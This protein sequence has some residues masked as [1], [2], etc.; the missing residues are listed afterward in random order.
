ME[1][2]GEPLEHPRG[3]RGRP[4]R[5]VTT[6]ATEHAS[7]S[8]GGFHSRSCWHYCWSL[9]AGTETQCYGQSVIC[10][11]RSVKS[12]SSKVVGRCSWSYSFTHNDSYGGLFALSGASLT[13]PPIQR[14]AV[15]TRVDLT[16]RH[17]RPELSFARGPSSPSRFDRYQSH[18]I[19]SHRKGG[20]L[21]ERLVG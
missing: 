8:V 15:V 6:A 14:S 17:G 1:V 2:R 3:R 21:R 12:I 7:F 19:E 11:L 10:C 4:R 18:E 9:Y 20:R 5:A 16:M 13:L